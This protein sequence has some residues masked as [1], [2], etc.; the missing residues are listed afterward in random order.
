MNAFALTAIVTF[1][2]FA[3]G[4]L[5]LL[6]SW[7]HARWREATENIGQILLSMAIGGLIALAAYIGWLRDES[8][9]PEIRVSEISGQT[10]GR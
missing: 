2:L 3:L 9:L 7:A 6:A 8:A 1:A 10:P 4:G 5:M